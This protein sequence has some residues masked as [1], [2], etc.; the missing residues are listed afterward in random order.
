MIPRY[1]RKQ[2]SEL[3]DDRMRF[4]RWLQVELAVARH[5]SRAGM[6]SAKDFR[7]LEKGV[8]S[9]LDSGGV[10]P[11]RIEEIE[12][13]TRHDVI[14]FTTAVTERLGPEGRW[15][16]F[17]L[18][19]SDVV[20]TALSMCLRDAGELLLLGLSGLEAELR[21][22]AREYRDLPCLGRTHG[23][24]AEPTSFGLKFLGWA[25]ETR[26]NRERLELAID[27]VRYGKLSGAVGCNS[28][29]E[30]DLEEKCLKDLGLKR[31]SVSTQ[32]IPRD[33]HARFVQTLA[34]AGCG[35]ERIA[36]ELR[37]LQRSEVAEVREGFAKGQKGSSAMPHKR[38]P[39]SSENITGCARVLR[40]HAAAC[41]E[42][43][44]LWHER[45]ISHSSVERIILPDAT[46]LLDYAVHRMTGII[47]KLELDS[48]RVEANLT[49]QGGVVG[50]GHVLLALVR[51]GVAREEA[52]A[53]VQA[54]AHSALDSISGAGGQ[55]KSGKPKPGFLE[56]LCGDPR[57]LEHLSRT[58]LKKLVSMK[59]QLR[60]VPDICKKAER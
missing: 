46:M 27:E 26:R 60:S 48:V 15:L 1:A 19:S 40:S 4:R 29:L 56:C 35:L 21:K 25:Q 31:E 36:V 37:H 42:N 11:V 59:F 39:I 10:D 53:W 57:I 9:I 45:D 20:D 2:M 13:V 30:P 44:V 52:Y 49:S 7:S 6:I 58:E 16:H 38:N 24:A 33:R 23:M 3:W 41:M 50:S 32:V 14:A 12:E 28:V 18:T 43:V 55:S 51:K 22:R 54:A 47:Q 5:Q 17:G 34:L 8:N